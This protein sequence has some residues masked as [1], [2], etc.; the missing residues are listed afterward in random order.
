MS[1]RRS[2]AAARRAAWRREGFGVNPPIRRPEAN[3]TEFISLKLLMPREVPALPF[4]NGE[5]DKTVT[6]GLSGGK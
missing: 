6:V 3:P 1:W 4:E 5:S 2:P